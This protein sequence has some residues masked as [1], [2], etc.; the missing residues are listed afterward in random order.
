MI[1]NDEKE[2]KEMYTQAAAKPPTIKEGNISDDD[3]IVE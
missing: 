3:E 2:D 1:V